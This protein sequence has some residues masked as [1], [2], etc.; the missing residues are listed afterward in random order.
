MPWSLIGFAS[1]YSY[2][3]YDAYRNGAITMISIDNAEHNGLK[4]PTIKCKL[5][6]QEI[7]NSKIRSMTSIRTGDIQVGDRVHGLGVVKH[8]KP[9]PKEYR[10]PQKIEFWIEGVGH[11]YIRNA[12]DLGPRW[13]QMTASGGGHGEKLTRLQGK[14][15]AALLSYSTLPEA[16]EA[17]SVSP[18][19]LRR[20]LKI[21]TFHDAFLEARRGVVSRA[22]GQVQGAMNIAVDALVE[23]ATNPDNP[24]ASRVAASKALMDLGLRGIEIEDFDCR[25]RELEKMM[26]G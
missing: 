2:V 12:T 7:T 22:I 3:R 15:V 10:K 11:P 24:P 21:E 1:T 5:S 23:V 8:I 17:A 19:T 26:K 4:H 9:Q 18:R 14:A 16:A 25:I 20:W 6:V 13:P